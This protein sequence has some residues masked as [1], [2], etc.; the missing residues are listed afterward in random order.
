MLTLPR[1]T[2]MSVHRNNDAESIRLSALQTRV[3]TLVAEGETDRSIA[4]R[5]GM[6]VSQVKHI[7]REV[8][9]RLDSRNRAHAVYEAAERGLI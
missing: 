5:L 3:L 1:E 7:L 4:A 8:L 2:A 9:I 6:S